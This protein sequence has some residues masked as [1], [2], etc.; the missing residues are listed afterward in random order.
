M[1]LIAKETAD[2]IRELRRQ[3]L[4]QEAVMDRLGVSHHAVMRYQDEGIQAHTWTDEETA[5]LKEL[6][7]AGWPGGRIAEKLPGKS[8]SAIMGKVKRLELKRSVTVNISNASENGRRVGAEYGG[9]RRKKAAHQQA[10]ARKVA[11]K[12][13]PVLRVVPVPAPEPAADAPLVTMRPEFFKP[14][15]ARPFMDRAPGQCAWPIDANGE[16]LACCDPVS[17]RSSGRQWCEH[18]TRAGQVAAKPRSK[19]RTGPIGAG[20]TEAMRRWA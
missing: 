20:W 4:S 5:T 17:A 18:H 11:A 2:K 16:L 1:S 9:N 3:G 12:A 10:K 13:P 14:K 7:L 6:W 15:A 19:A 8:R